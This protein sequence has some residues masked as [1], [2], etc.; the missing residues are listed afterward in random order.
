M[1]VRTGLA[2]LSPNHIE[3]S[4]S[5]YNRVEPPDDWRCQEKDALDGP[6]TLPETKQNKH[7]IRFVISHHPTG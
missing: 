7:S 2:A 1:D 5:R 4:L 3:R 6:K